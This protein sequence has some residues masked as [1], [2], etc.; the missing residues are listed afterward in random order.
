[1]GCKVVIQERLECLEGF[2]CL[3]NFE[4]VEYLRALRGILMYSGFRRFAV[5]GVFWLFNGLESL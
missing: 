2:E 4:G 1:M 5:P 3:Q